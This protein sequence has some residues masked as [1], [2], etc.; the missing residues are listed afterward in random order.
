LTTSFAKLRHCRV[1]QRQCF[2]IG[3]GNNAQSRTIW[4]PNPEGDFIAQE[5]LFH[6]KPDGFHLTLSGVETE[7]SVQLKAEA[8][9]WE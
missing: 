1:C 5:E 3:L 6:D 9:D 8:F 4:R 2:L 7:I